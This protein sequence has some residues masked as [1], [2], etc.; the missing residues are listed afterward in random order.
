MQIASAI[1]P[2]RARKGQPIQRLSY[3]GSPGPNRMNSWVAS[4]RLSRLDF[5]DRLDFGRPSDTSQ[6][7][8]NLLFDHG[9]VLAPL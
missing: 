2:P 5:E 1:P 9:T 8:L 4:I 7:H 6:G 3:F